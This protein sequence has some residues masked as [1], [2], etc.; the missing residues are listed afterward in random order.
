MADGT[1]CDGTERDAA[2]RPDGLKGDAA[3]YN[4]A[5]RNAARPDGSKG[6]AAGYND[7]EGNTAR[8][9]RS[10]GDAAGYNAAERD[11][12]RPDGSKRDAAGYN[13]AERNAAR[14]DGSKGD[15]ARYND[16]KRNAARS[17]G[18]KGDA[19]GYNA[20]E[21]NAARSNGPE[22]DA[23]RY[24]D[25]KQ[26]A[27][28]R[29]PAD[30]IEEWQ[31][32]QNSDE[33]R[34]LG[35]CVFTCFF[36]VILLL[37]QQMQNILTCQVQT[38][39]GKSMSATSVSAAGCIRSAISGQ[40]YQVPLYQQQLDFP[41]NITYNTPMKKIEMMIISF[42]ETGSTLNA[43]LKSK[44]KEQGIS[45]ESYST[46]RFAR[47]DCGM[48]SLPEDIKAWIGEHW[49]KA[50]FIFIGASGIAIRYIAPWVRDKFT[51][52]PVVVMDEKGRFVIP[53]LSGHMGGAVEIAAQISDWI[54]AVP[55]ITTATDVQ[56]KFA[57]DVFAKKNGLQITD[58]RL[59]KEISAAVLEG[60]EIGFI[61]SLP[62]SG[63]LPEELK[64][65][66]DS[67]ELGHYA[68]GIAVTDG[69]EVVEETVLEGSNVLR[70]HTD[71]D[72]NQ[73]KV[74]VGIGCRRGTKKERLECGLKNVLDKNQIRPGQI[75]AFASIELKK[76]EAG[77]LELAEEYGVPFQTFSV[78]EL[79]TVS[80][81]SS[82]SA[83]VEQTTGVDNVCER[84][85]RYACQEGVLIQT[86]ICEAGC[87]FALVK[88][89]VRLAF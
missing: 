21:G 65:C 2:T 39:P 24:N 67:K 43:V 35:F 58:R 41:E 53:L 60:K 61:S 87:T 7:A 76:D 12:A 88:R 68:Y 69:D 64:W 48:H 16:A 19:A 30:R 42:T 80:T 9:D 70:L 50:G 28:R 74:V 26:N 84:A 20:A 55:V 22:G 13:A 52:S 38:M 36:Q 85:A 86:K 44:F 25:A 83:F 66:S 63:K 31:K 81:V 47:R 75:E 59:A 56:G 62:V 51:D 4:A 37:T 79:R 89:P 6:G 49:G 54:G 82:H 45:C 71:P 8:P 23:A 72:E 1:R 27:A 3:G 32:T 10:K 29:Y 11:A 18:S 5:E 77:L 40:L 15:A 14:S 57:V 46:E 73:E 17:N 33:K 78:E 34:R